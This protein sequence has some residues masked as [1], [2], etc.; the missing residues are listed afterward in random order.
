M[1]ISPNPTPILRDQAGVTWGE[2]PRAPPCVFLTLAR[3]HCLAMRL[4][5]KGLRADVDE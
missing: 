3:P 2:V 4:N 1:E 5:E